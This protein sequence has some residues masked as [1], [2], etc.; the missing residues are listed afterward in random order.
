MIRAVRT[1]PIDIELGVPRSSVTSRTEFFLASSNRWPCGTTRAEVPPLERIGLKHLRY[2]SV[3]RASRPCAHWR[4]G[5]RASARIENGDGNARQTVARPRGFEHDIEIIHSRRRCGNI[6]GGRLARLAAAR[7]EK[8][9]EHHHDPCAEPAPARSPR[10]AN[11]DG[12]PHAR[13]KHLHGRIATRERRAFLLLVLGRFTRGPFYIVATIL[14]L[15][16]VVGTGTP[17][18]ECSSR[19]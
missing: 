8:C 13:P 17:Q 16:T 5:P 11:E 15:C 10:S 7:F 14:T 3:G 2:R 9:D 4:R 1:Y 18:V 6:R 12:P 19:S